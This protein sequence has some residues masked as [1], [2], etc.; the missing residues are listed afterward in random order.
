MTVTINYLSLFLN[1]LQLKVVEDKI[2]TLFGAIRE[3][4]IN[5]FFL[6]KRVLNLFDAC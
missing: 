3:V 5:F 2:P 1:K 6:F 4:F